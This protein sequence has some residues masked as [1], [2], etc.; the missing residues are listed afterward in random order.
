MMAGAGPSN[1]GW[2]AGLA[3]VLPPLIPAR[4]GARSP[5]AELSEYTDRISIMYVPA[6]A[7]HSVLV[8][9]MGS[10]GAPLVIDA[11]SAG[12]TGGD[13]CGFAAGDTLLIVDGPGAGAPYDVFSVADATAGAVSPG[14]PLS[15]PYTA[16]SRVMRV[17]QRVYY[18]DRATS[19]LM[20]YDGNASDL[21]LVDHIVDLR[22]AY[23]VDPSSSAVAAPVSGASCVYAE[24]PPP[25]PLLT[26]L[27]GR[28]L[29]RL[30]ATQL[31]DGPVCGASPHRFDGDLLRVRRVQ[32]VIRA[33]CESAECRG[34]GA[35]FVHPGIAQGG[36]RVV[37][38][39]EIVVDVAPRN[40][41]LD[42]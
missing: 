28:A 19:R 5:D 25:V 39:Q 40:M 12:C 38:D 2:V 29:R 10:A 42:R 17:V 27:G 8:S 16:N 33:E 20:L 23:F 32:V 30:T 31:T 6:G 21:P 24:G 15:R 41:N 3:R 35:R 13:T 34:S 11:G 9:E 4:T 18:L 7:P 22:V 14:Q 37:P 36:V 1:A 26:D